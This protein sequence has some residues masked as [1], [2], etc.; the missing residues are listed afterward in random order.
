MVVRSL[1]VVI[2]AALA[3]PARADGPTPYVPPDFMTVAPPL[4]AGENGEAAWR[5][6][7]A[8]ALQIAAHRNLGLVVER[9]NLHIADLGITV[10]GAP[11]E[12]LLT[13]GYLH[14]SAF[15]PPL[16]S[17]DGSVGELF[18]AHEDDWQI[19]LAQRLETGT[20]LAV[21]LTSSRTASTLGTA[22][23]PLAYRTNVSVSVVQPL[24]RGF[25]LDRA[26]PRVAILRAHIVSDRERFQ[27]VVAATDII[28]QTEDAYW[29]VV[30][31]LYRHDLERKSQARA[32][33]QLALTQRQI[34]AGTL[35]PSDLIGVQSTVAQHELS[36]VSSEESV[37][38]SW[39]VLRG[40]LNL[41][42]EE[43]ARPI[44]P[45][46]MP[47]FTAAPTTD[48]D[49]LALAL[50]NRPDLAQADLD[51]RGAAL[52]VRVAE[53]EE[54][55]QLDLGVT[56]AVLGQNAGYGQAVRQAAEADAHA[57]QVT[58]N[59]SWTP[60]MRATRAAA[61]IEQHRHQQSLV[62]RTQ[63]VQTIW[64]QVREA[65]R[66]QRSAARLVA[67][68]GAARELAE[69]TLAIEQRRFLNGTSSNINVAAK[70]EELANAQIAELGAVL[71]HKKATSSL[72]RATGRLLAERHVEL[73]MR[74]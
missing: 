20:L 55:P 8:Q 74:R 39:D 12:P 50:A 36:V 35:P 34:A 26:V 37:R 60:L 31:A 51:V 61:E 44:L 23:A 21:N 7:L 71:A 16:T 63:L 28:K 6:D 52:G 13:A 40:V 2:L 45:V 10:A 49:E 27:L 5:L 43:W 68:A 25:S 11:F 17:V 30:Q 66:T 67:A 69:Q 9:D 22:V 38:Q 72:L 29:D 57:W 46:D 54:R 41:P 32:R 24:G 18:A 42:H 47:Q 56:A 4:P 33:E 65:V 59:M 48:E 19:G 3:A 1:G 58:L 62:A 73:D 15:E 64:L 53:N 14:S 70:Q